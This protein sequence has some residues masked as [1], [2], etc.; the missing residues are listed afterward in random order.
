MPK[1]NS[2][3]FKGS[4]KVC[5]IFEIYSKTSDS[6]MVKKRYLFFHYKRENFFICHITITQN[7][8]A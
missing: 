3:A 5:T 2:V 7:K 1:D 4:F 6:R 8:H